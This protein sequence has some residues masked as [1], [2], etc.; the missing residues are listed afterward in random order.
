MKDPRDPDLSGGRHK[1]LGDTLPEG[2]SPSQLDGKLVSKGDIREANASVSLQCPAPESWFVEYEIYCCLVLIGTRLWFNYLTP[3]RRVSRGSCAFLPLPLL[4]TTRRP[5]AIHSIPLTLPTHLPTSFVTV[6]RRS[7]ICQRTRSSI[8]RRR[9]WSRSSDT[10]RSLKS[11][12]R[13]LKT[14]P[15]LQEPPKHERLVSRFHRHG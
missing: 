10:Y 12:S 15:G 6:V 7:S 5:P 8:C 3:S 14:R 4:P 13:R 9:T 2:K 1:P 11:S